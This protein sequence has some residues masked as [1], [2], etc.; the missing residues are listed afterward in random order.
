MTAVSSGVVEGARLKLAK[1]AP[2]KMIVPAVPRRP[3]YCAANVSSI[4]ANVGT[5]DSKPPAGAW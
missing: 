2:A 3:P 5:S 1:D 4:F